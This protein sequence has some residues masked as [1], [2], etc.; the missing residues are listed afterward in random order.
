MASW[1]DGSWHSPWQSSTAAQVCCQKLSQKVCDGM[2]LSVVTSHIQ[3]RQVRSVVKGGWTKAMQM[4]QRK[5]NVVMYSYKLLHG[6][7]CHIFVWRALSGFSCQKSCSSPNIPLPKFA[8]RA[9]TASE[10]LPRRGGVD[11]HGSTR[12]QHWS[13]FTAISFSSLLWL[14]W[15][16][17]AFIVFHPSVC[18]NESFPV[19]LIFNSFQMISDGRLVPFIA[20]PWLS[21]SVNENTL[22]ITQCPKKVYDHMTWYDINM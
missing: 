17:L 16:Y 6:C 15:F 1:F 2:P 8:R 11:Q 13:L 18:M 10:M 19:D 12:K 22:W 5:R 4:G 14:I 9:L 7:I 3:G 21:Q 20:A